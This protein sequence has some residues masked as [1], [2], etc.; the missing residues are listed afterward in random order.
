MLTYLSRAQTPPK[1][2]QL[3]YT[4]TPPPDFEPGSI[5]LPSSAAADLLS[6]SSIEGKQIWH[7]TVPASVPVDSIKEVSM[8]SVQKGEAALSYKGANYGFVIDGESQKVPKRMFL[9]DE[10]NNNYR[11]AA[12]AICQ[13]LHLQQL[14]NLPNSG[15]A[16]SVPADGLQNTAGPS[17]SFRRA[18][19]L[20]PKGLKMRYLPFGDTEGRLGRMGPGSSTSGGSDDEEP[21]FRVP[22]GVSSSGKTRK[23]KHN[24]R[25]GLN[26]GHQLL[27]ERRLKRS[28]SE[29]DRPP[30]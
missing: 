24:A 11:P 25:D 7:I 27:E 13:T 30:R 22:V 20:Q 9:P 1:T 19:R 21:Q 28:K 10:R 3:Q 17:H 23:R 16:S 26:D 6:P 15:T 5:S 8:Q 29:A 14:V 18:V 4:Y 2:S 12:M